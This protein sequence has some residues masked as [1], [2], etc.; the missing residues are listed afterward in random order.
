[1]KIK[2]KKVYCEN[3]IY[4]KEFPFYEGYEVGCLSYKDT[5]E[6]PNVKDYDISFTLNK[7]NKCKRYKEKI[8][9]LK[10]TDKNNKKTSFIKRLLERLK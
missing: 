1:M 5:P 4:Y 9:V 3:C 6:R 8:I 2:T 10:S 7:N